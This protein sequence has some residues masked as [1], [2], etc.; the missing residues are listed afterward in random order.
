MTV[1]GIREL[2]PDGGFDGH[3]D[4]AE[5]KEVKQHFHFSKLVRKKDA[6]LTKK[7]RK[8]EWLR[9]MYMN[10]LAEEKKEGQLEAID[11]QAGVVKGLINQGKA[12]GA[13]MYLNHMEE[14]G[15]ME[16]IEID[17]GG[18]VDVEV[19]NL[20]NWTEELDYEEYVGNW[21]NIGTSAGTGGEEK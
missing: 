2:S 19:E 6:E 9:K 4:R 1:K 21:S 5:E 17:E 8:R 12:G 11:M 3:G 15:G 16:A 20:L 7:R 18:I 13:S 10:G 14:T